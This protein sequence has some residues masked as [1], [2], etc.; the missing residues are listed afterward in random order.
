MKAIK[1]WAPKQFLAYVLLYAAHADIHYKKEEKEH[2]LSKVGDDAYQEAYE[3]FVQ[4]NSYIQLR[5]I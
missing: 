3:E 1:K 2:I 4:D 5:K